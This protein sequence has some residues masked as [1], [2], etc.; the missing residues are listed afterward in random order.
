MVLG[1]RGAEPD[2]METLLLITTITDLVIMTFSTNVLSRP[3]RTHTKRYDT[4]F[5]ELPRMYVLLF[6]RSLSAASFLL[7]RLL[8][9]ASLFCLSSDRMKTTAELYI[10][11]IGS[12][13]KGG[14][15]ETGAFLSGLPV[16]YVPRRND[17]SP[18]HAHAVRSA[19]G[20]V[21]IAR[22]SSRPY[23]FIHRARILSEGK[24]P[25]FS[26]KD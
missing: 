1:Q 8:L 19:Q 20:V 6:T 5:V 16:S 3:C 12:T 24:L 9:F 11:L 18:S 26:Q 2:R 22:A 13:R 25:G 23:G 21:S 4:R 14:V 15:C 17:W 10:A 7:N